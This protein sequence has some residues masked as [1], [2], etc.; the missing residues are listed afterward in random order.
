MLLSKSMDGDSGGE[1]GF[2]AGRQSILEVSAILASQTEDE[3]A[4]DA[5]MLA[6]AAYIISI[7]GDRSTHIPV[8]GAPLCVCA[9][10]GF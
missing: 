8:W 2:V 1:G 10:N 9:S 7:H 5:H 6:S 3:D 4:A